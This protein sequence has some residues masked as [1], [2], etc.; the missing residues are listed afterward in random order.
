M[1]LRRNRLVFGWAAL[2]FIVGF[3]AFGAMAPVGAWFFAAYILGLLAA[4]YL[5]H[6]RHLRDIHAGRDRAW[7]AGGAVGCWK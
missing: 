6:R 5:D 7:P 3:F 2:A 4:A 1:F